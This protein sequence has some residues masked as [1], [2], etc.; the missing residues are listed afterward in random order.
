MSGW[1]L[2]LLLYSRDRLNGRMLM[3]FVHIYN[4]IKVATQKIPQ[5]GSHSEKSLSFWN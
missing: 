1:V 2:C 5:A 3:R 4:I